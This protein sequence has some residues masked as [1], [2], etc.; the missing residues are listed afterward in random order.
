M[1]LSHGVHCWLRIKVAVYKVIGAVVP[2]IKEMFPFTAS[3]NYRAIDSFG[4]TC[5]VLEIF[6][7]EM[8]AFSPVI[9]F[10]IYTCLKK[11]PRPS[12]QFLFHIPLQEE[13]VVTGMDADIIGVLT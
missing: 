9:L 13:V 12:L 10:K 6:A 7:V 8:S 4:V 11:I 5:L 1:Q 2:G 3:A